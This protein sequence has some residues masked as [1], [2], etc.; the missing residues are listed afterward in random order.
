MDSKIT[1]SSLTVFPLKSAKG[2]SVPKATI[3]Q[4]GFAH[5]RRWMITDMEG[6]FL[7]QRVFTQLALVETQ[8]KDGKIEIHA[9]NMGA[10]AFTSEPTMGKTVEVEVW[11]DEC[12]AIAPDEKLN[13]W[14]SE[15]LDKECQVVYMPDISERLVEKDY[16]PGEKLVSFADGFPFLLISEA[17]LADLNSR[18][19][20]PVGMERFRPNIVVS[21]GEAFQEDGWKKIR[22]GEA[23]FS[24]SKPC[25]RCV[26]TTVDPLTGEKGKEPLKTL[27]SYRKVG[28][29]IMFGQNLLC[30]SGSKVALGDKLEVLE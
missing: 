28:K 5:D 1:V 25:A 24:V 23:V 2:I 20:T 21:G 19:D 14:M 27:A 9:P 18:L 13:R 4:T 3:S 16:N 11:G 22:I 30:E 17:S 7:T 10:Y 6:Q 26:L 12:E 8:L 29:K 15:F